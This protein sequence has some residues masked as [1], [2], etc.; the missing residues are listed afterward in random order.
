MAE[1]HRMIRLSTS[2]ENA[3]H[4]CGVEH[5]ARETSIHAMNMPC[6]GVEQLAR[7][8]PR[9]ARMI[10]E[11]YKVSLGSAERWLRLRRARRIAWSVSASGVVT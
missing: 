10:G 3:E 7:G 6:P 9:R 2:T 11:T 1:F 4:V 5:R 8:L